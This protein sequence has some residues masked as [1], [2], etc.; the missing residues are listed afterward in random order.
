M[1]ITVRSAPSRRKPAPVNGPMKGTPAAVAMGCAA[2][3][4]GV[5]TAPISANTPCC[6]ISVRVLAMAASGS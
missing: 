5:P 2:A 1:L 4:V 6:P 3:D